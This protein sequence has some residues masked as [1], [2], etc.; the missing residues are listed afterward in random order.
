MPDLP[1]DFVEGNRAVAIFN[2]LRL[3]DVPGTPTM[4]DAG[5]DWFRDIVRTLFGARRLEAKPEQLAIHG[6]AFSSVLGRSVR[7]GR[8]LGLEVHQ[9]SLG[10]HQIGEA[11]QRVQ[12]PRTRR[13]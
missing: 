13:R 9:R 12:L 10:D 6:P 1:L 5:G 7:S 8:T 4:G 3:A 2:R 11:E